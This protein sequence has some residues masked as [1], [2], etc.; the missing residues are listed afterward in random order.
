[1]NKSCTYVRTTGVLRFEPVIFF[2]INR[3]SQFHA[4]KY[5]DQGNEKEATIQYGWLMFNS[6][7]SVQKALLY[8]GHDISRTSLYSA[9]L[10][11]FLNSPLV[12][13]SSH[14]GS[15]SDSL[16]AVAVLIQT[17]PR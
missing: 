3:I 11:V 17:Y 14:W 2:I 15:T 8:T 10:I 6:S 1:M 4:P 7:V 12:T 5:R 16:N 9:F 13:C